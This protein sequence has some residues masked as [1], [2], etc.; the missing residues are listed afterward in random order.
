MD[1]LNTKTASGKAFKDV[2]YFTNSAGDPIYCKYWEPSGDASPKGMILIVHGYAAHCARYDELALK[3]NELG[4]SVFSHDHTF[5]GENPGTCDIVDYRQY[6]RDCLQ[7]IDIMRARNPM[8]P[9]YLF[10]HSMG[11]CISVFLDAENPGLFKAMVLSSPMLALNRELTAWKVNLLRPV[12]AVMPWLPVGR[13]DANQ[14]TCDIKEVK[15]YLDDPLIYTGAVRVRQ[16]IQIYEM[17]TAVQALFEQVKVPFL[18]LHGAEDLICE[19]KGSQ[20]LMEKAVLAED[21]KLRVFEGARHELLHEGG[22][23]PGVF[24]REVC[25][26]LSAHME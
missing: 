7:H 2:N 6:M 10:G 16:A 9:L 25:D 11:G 26:W 23:V 18:V 19:L 21:K 5:H 4:L 8:L 14:I 22:D 12:G 3:F 17:G 15:K 13:L 24:V 20:I 1:I